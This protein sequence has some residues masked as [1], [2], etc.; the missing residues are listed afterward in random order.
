MPLRRGPP[1]RPTQTTFIS[2]KLQGK[3]FRQGGLRQG[4]AGRGEGE[5][6]GRSGSTGQS[7]GPHVH[8]EVLMDGRSINPLS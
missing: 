7:T 3:L 4:R 6:I 1:T 5:L 8:Y 2:P